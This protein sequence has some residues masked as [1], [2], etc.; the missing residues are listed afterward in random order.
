MRVLLTGA[1]GQLGKCFQDR[2]PKGWLI[3]KTDTKTL[4]ITDRLAVLTVVDSFKPDVIV[5]AAAY[6]AVDKAEK[7]SQIAA[8]VNELGPKNLAEAAL[9]INAKFIHISTDYVF[10]GKSSTPY[11]EDDDTSPLGVYGMTK[12]NGEQSVLSVNDSAIVIRT[13]WVF[14]EYGNNFVKTMLKLGIERQSLSIVSDQRGCPTYAGDIANTILQL[15]QYENVEGG[16]YHYC[17]DKEVSWFEFANKIFEQA[18]KLGYSGDPKING[19]TTKEYPTLAIRPSYS[20]LDCQKIKQYNNISLS[21]WQVA[22][23][24]ICSKLF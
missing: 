13:A 6:T 15:I 19:I 10:D 24:N 16:I 2:L 12:L 21:D 1:N 22:L 5:N 4:D 17:G 9:A 23:V 3:L 8:L 18:K 7:D 11:K 14:S 20:V